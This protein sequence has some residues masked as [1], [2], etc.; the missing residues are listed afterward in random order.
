WD[1]EDYAISYPFIPSKNFDYRRGQLKHSKIFNE[2][3]QKIKEVINEYEFANE[4]VMT[5]GLRLAIQN[6]GGCPYA[7]EYKWYSS[8]K[9]RYDA[10]QN[11]IG[12]SNCEKLCGFPASHIQIHRIEEA[13]GWTRLKKSVTKEYF[14]NGSVPNVVETIQNYTYNNTN[15][16]VQT[17]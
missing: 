7:Y 6:G 13:I 17:Q 2:N 5:T 1:I 10:C 11:G 15:K 14:Y 4:S 16:Q 12:G 9:A 3:N 8:Y